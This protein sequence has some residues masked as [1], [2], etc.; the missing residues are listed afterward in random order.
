[1][2]T[3]VEHA[4]THAVLGGLIFDVADEPGEGEAPLLDNCMK[5]G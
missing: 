5:R 1:M 4:A 3:R 2:G